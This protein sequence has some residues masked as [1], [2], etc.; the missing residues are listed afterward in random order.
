M[1]R[2]INYDVGTRF[3]TFDTAPFQLSDAAIERDF[4][5]I[6]DRLHCDA[7]QIYGSDPQRLCET[8]ILARRLTL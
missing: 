7:I 1:I 4:M 2:G 3:G 5:A 6:R 8:S